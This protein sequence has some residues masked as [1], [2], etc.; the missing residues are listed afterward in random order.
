MKLRTILAASAIG[1]LV[2][3]SAALAQT[4]PVN[5]GTDI[6]GTVPSFLELII[7]QPAKGFATFSKTKAYDMSFDVS[8]TATDAPTQL[9]LADGDA[10]SGSKLGHLSVGSKRLASPLEAAVGK[11]AFQPLDGSVDPLLTKWTQAAT[12]AKTTVKLRQKVTGK[13]TGS[14]HKLVLATLSTETP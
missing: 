12:R 4:P 9:S 13:A 14:Y 3:P 6:G 11:T 7:T 8:M 1:A 5:G 2:A 10:T